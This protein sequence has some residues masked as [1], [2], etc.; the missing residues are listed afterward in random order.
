MKHIHKILSSILS[1]LDYHIVSIDKD[2]K[3]PLIGRN[4]IETR[5]KIGRRWIL[6]YVYDMVILTHEGKLISKN[7]NHEHHKLGY[8]LYMHPYCRRMDNYFTIT[9]ASNAI[10]NA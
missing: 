1:S 4:G 7:Y 6:S 8:V 2:F 5:A 10:S 3:M 9:S